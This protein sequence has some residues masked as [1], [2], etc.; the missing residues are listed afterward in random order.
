MALA[1]AEAEAESTAEVE[2]EAEVEVEVEAERR[3][4]VSPKPNRKPK[5][6]TCSMLASTQYSPGC[7]S[8]VTPRPS[9]PPPPPPRDQAKPLPDARRSAAFSA[10]PGPPGSPGPASTAGTAG[11]VDTTGTANSAAPPPSLP[12]PPP[13]PPPLPLPLPPPPLL[14]YLFFV[15]F[16]GHTAVTNARIFMFLAFVRP[17]LVNT[18]SRTLFLALGRRPMCAT[19]FYGRV[20]LGGVYGRWTS[21]SV[22]LG[23]GFSEN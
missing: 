20:N 13:P 18:T 8:S 16:Y 2:A 3:F 5:A 21:S 17:R 15:R 23:M 7:N 4:S 1:M 14:G 9:S 10:P 11:S 22:D 6:A 12:P 19:K